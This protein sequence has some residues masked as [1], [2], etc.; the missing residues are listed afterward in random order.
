MSRAARYLVRIKYSIDSMCFEVI[1]NFD[2][3]LEKLNNGIW[4][5]LA[6]F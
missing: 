6:W 2:Y 3:H 1:F 4:F 5:L